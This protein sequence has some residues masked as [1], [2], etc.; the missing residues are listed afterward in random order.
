MSH[1]EERSVFSYLLF[2]DGSG[3]FPRRGYTTE[4]WCSL[5]PKPLTAKGL[6]LHNLVT[7]TR[8]DLG[9]RLE[10]TLS[11]EGVNKILKQTTKKTAFHWE[12]NIMWTA[13]ITQQT[14]QQIL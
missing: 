10:M 9:K 1:F 4:E 7:I 12:K 2:K 6:Y 3:N 11:T 5:V 14:L 13:K 8:Y